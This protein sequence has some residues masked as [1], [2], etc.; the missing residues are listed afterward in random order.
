LLVAL[1]VAAGELPYNEAADAKAELK[2]VLIDARSAQKP[3]LVIFGANWCED[4]RALDRSL[5]SGKNAELIAGEFEVV[6]IDVGRFDRNLDVSK[7]YGDPIKT[8]IPAA[9]ILSPTS[10]MLY[11]TRAG[12]LANARKMNDEGVYGFFKEAIAKA[13]SQN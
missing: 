10:E 7:I 2:K 8:G 13:K 12:E 11:S 6:K 3:V 1:A 4:C 5:K 9:V